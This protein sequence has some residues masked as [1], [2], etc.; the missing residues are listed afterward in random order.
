[1]TQTNI[2]SLLQVIVPPTDRGSNATRTGGDGAGFDDHLSKAST[3]IDSPTSDNSQPSSK[4][5]PASQ[6][7]GSSEAGKTSECLAAQPERDETDEATAST[8]EK[9]SEQH[10]DDEVDEAT[11]AAAGAVQ[12]AASNESAQKP[13]PKTHAA[14]HALQ[15]HA[16]DAVVNE[17]DFAEKPRS[18][19]KVEVAKCEKKAEATTIDTALATA[20]TQH[21]V[22]G[23]APDQ[24]T[25]NAE[26]AEQSAESEPTQKQMKDGK[27]TVATTKGAAEGTLATVEAQSNQITIPDKGAIAAEN[28][29]EQAAE[30]KPSAVGNAKAAAKATKAAES[31]AGDDSAADKPSAQTT[32]PNDLGVSAA[33]AAAAAIAN[34]VAA[35]VTAPSRMDGDR[36]KDS[37]EEAVKAVSAKADPP[38]GSLDRLNR[39]ASELTNGT[40][41]AENN[42]TPRVDPARF[43]GRVAKAFHTAHERGGPLQLRLSPPELGALRIQLTVKDG[44]MSAALET[45]NAGAKRVLLDNLP[46]LRD[47]LAEQNIRIEKFD[48]DV[49]QEGSGGQANPHGSNQNPYQPQPDRSVPRAGRA[50]PQVAEVAMRELPEA[51]P[52]ISSSGINLFV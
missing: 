35:D 36:T 51:A 43:V 29:S 4:L 22:S 49:R 20:E 18:S 50:Q 40:R 26:L 7:S 14:D 17:K 52:Q 6:T 37:S 23:D 9:E 42:D 25:G 48:V 33:K 15:V 41:S 38:L 19:A 10:S 34:N 21:V 11:A 31:E 47:R 13:E 46:A 24:P 8:S 3:S 5:S 12:P 2:D 44:V 28:N 16:K 30:G 27:R 39:A 1:M 45:D 32:L